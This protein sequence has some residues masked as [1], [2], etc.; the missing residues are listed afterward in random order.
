MFAI[1]AKTK[2]NKR[3][4]FN[5]ANVFMSVSPLNQSDVIK[6]L[7]K[8]S[9]INIKRQ[10]HFLTI[11]I[12]Y[13]LCEKWRRKLVL[14]VN[15]KVKINFEQKITKWNNKPL[16]AFC[17]IEKENLVIDKVIEVPKCWVN[18]EEILFYSRYF[19]YILERA[20]TLQYDVVYLVVGCDKE[21]NNKNKDKIIRT[22]KEHVKY[23][24]NNPKWSIAVYQS[25]KIY[26]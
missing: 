21:I 19:R 13:V 3:N 12:C 17:Y 2:A 6:I 8:W 20:Q 10:K 11:F 25:G 26:I 1:E 4:F 7:E 15:N 14:E 24:N 23:Y 16:I 5:D 18:Y 22:I 9:K